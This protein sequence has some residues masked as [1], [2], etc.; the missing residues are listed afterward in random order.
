MDARKGRGD[1]VSVDSRGEGI[2]CSVE[3][4]G[5]VPYPAFP[6]LAEAWQFFLTGNNALLIK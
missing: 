1:V 2:E 4:R 3:L 6:T 5:N